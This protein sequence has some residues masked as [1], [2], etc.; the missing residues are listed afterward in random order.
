MSKTIRLS[1]QAIQHDILAS[2]GALPWLRIWRSNTGLARPIN[3]PEA[4]VRFGVKGSADISGILRRDGR[5]LEIEVKAHR[6]RQ[7]VEQLAYQA[8]ITRMGGLYVLAR[9]VEDVWEA[10]K[11]YV[12]GDR[13]RGSV[14]GQA[15][16]RDNSR[17]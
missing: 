8:M 15:S 12:E 11:D 3:R 2:F 5:R 17:P 13:G 10:L 9:S 7:T 4:V 6:G 1:E 16:K 14:K